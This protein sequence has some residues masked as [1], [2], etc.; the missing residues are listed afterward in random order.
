[1]TYTTQGLGGDPAPNYHFQYEAMLATP[2]FNNIEPGRTFAVELGVMMDFDMMQ[3]WFGGIALDVNLPISV[4][5]TQFANSAAWSLSGR[6]L[7]ITLNPGGGDPWLMRYLLVAEMVEQFMRAQGK[8]W[9]GNNTEGSVG[10][11]LSQFL[12]AQFALVWGDT[13][14][15]HLHQI[16]PVNFEYSNYW[17][18]SNR[19]DFINNPDRS[20]SNRNE[21]SACSLLF[22]YYLKDQLNFTVAQIVAAGAADLATVY[23]NLTG[24]S[25]DPFPAFKQTLDAAFPNQGVIT[26]SNF[27]NPFPI[28]SG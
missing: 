5:V 17:L 3:R 16:P 12:A 25:N 18:A 20:N 23:R 22:L 8:G 6:D 19:I 4:N 13:A 24:N 26:K 7:T 11:G 9:Y 21:K 2:Q 1:M 27:D 10:E 15:E 14:M 28:A